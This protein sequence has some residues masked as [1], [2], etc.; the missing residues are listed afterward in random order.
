MA[1]LET[2]GPEVADTHSALYVSH[3]SNPA[4]VGSGIKVAR[5]T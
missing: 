4:K 3:S 1:R 2:I 5:H